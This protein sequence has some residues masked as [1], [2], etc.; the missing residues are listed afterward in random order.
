LTS[1]L[2]DSPL[3]PL[4]AQNTGVGTNVGPFGGAQALRDPDNTLHRGVPT[5]RYTYVRYVGSGE[6]GL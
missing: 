6:E 5:H 2:R 3:D 1:I 4:F